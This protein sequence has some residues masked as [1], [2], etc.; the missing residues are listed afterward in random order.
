MHRT[1][2][3]SAWLSSLSWRLWRL[4]LLLDRL[5]VSAQQAHNPLVGC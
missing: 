1:E 4:L 2:V 3:F 5:S